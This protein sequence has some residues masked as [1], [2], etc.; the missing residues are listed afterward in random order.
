MALT[1]STTARNA[2][3]DGLVD[4]IDAGGAGTLKFYTA[5]FATLLATLT[6][7]ATAFGAAGAVTPGVATAATIT[8][9]SSADATGTAAV[10]RIASGGGTALIDGTV[11]TS[12]ADINFNTVGWTSGDNIS[13]SSLTITVPAS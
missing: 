10:F 6:F 4:A 11:G 8:A 2:A 5:A 3:C 1:L 7:S 9:D 13:V 12:G